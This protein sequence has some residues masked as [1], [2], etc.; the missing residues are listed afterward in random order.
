[1]ANVI[2]ISDIRAKAEVIDVSALQQNSI[3]SAAGLIAPATEE[4]HCE[5]APEHAADPIKS[6]DDIYKVS[7]YFISNKQY[8][9][10]MLFIVGINFGLRASDLRVLRF[11]N[12][13]NDNFTYR[14]NFP[15]FEQKTRNTRKRKRT[16]I[17]Q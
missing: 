4:T 1:M 8:R 14:D 6:L 10:N 9:N 3:K 15:V 5:L 2:N 17:S 11:S 16:V 13:I 12:L 7:E